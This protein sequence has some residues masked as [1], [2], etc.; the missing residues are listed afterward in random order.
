M[1]ATWAGTVRA[2]DLKRNRIASLEYRRGGIPAAQGRHWPGQRRS[3]D[4]E[5]A[6]SLVRLRSMW[7]VRGL[8]ELHD[9]LL[10]SMFHTAGPPADIQ[11][12]G[13]LHCPSVTA[14]DRSFPTVLVHTWHGVCRSHARH[15]SGGMVDYMSSKAARLR[16]RQAARRK[17]DKRLRKSGRV[18]QHTRAERRREA[19]ERQRQHEIDHRRQVRLRRLTFSALAPVGAASVI[20]TSVVEFNVHHS[21]PFLSATASTGL[22]NPDL[23]HM[24]EQ[25]RTDY[26]SSVEAGTASTFTFVGPVAPMSWDGSEHYRSYGPNIFGD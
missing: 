25:D 21:Y 11:V 13:D 16:R 19:A 6:S 17:L 2:G 7:P 26:T 23:P 1:P 5:F 24:P 20:V 12:S 3:I 4:P 9:P 18:P 8:V 15:A 10:R 14:G 22:G